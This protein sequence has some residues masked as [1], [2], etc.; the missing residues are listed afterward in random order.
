MSTLIIVHPELQIAISVVPLL[1]KCELFKTNPILFNSPYQVQS[2]VPLV[3]L[4]EFLTALEGKRVKI[5]S[6]NHSFLSVL[7]NEFGFHGLDTDLTTFHT[8]SLVSTLEAR[9]RALEERIANADCEIET[10]HRTVSRLEKASKSP[11]VEGGRTSPKPP[12]IKRL[13]SVIVDGL[14]EILEDVCQQQRFVLLWRGSR[15]GFQP[16]DFHSRCDGHPNTLTLIQDS[17][18]NIFGGFTPVEWESRT[19]NEQ[20]W[21][22]NNCPKADGSLKTFLFTLKNPSGLAP[23]KFS[24]KPDWNRSAIYCDKDQG[25]VFGLEGDVTIRSNCNTSSSSYANYFGHTFLNDTGLPG[26]TFLTGSSSFRVKEIEVFE[27]RP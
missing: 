25:P 18:G 26:E 8:L 14:P 27:L 15:D 21:E 13:N 1:T 22:Q 19:W 24:L 5:T 20:M 23:R 7:S 3:V 2:N 12:A 4:R 9:V 16:R 11:S 17:D 10:L 6:N